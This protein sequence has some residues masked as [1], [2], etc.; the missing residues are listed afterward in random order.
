VRNTFRKERSLSALQPLIVLSW[1]A[2]EQFTQRHGAYRRLSA[3]QTAKNQ[4]REDDPTPRDE[5]YLEAL[6][7]PLGCEPSRCGTPS[8][9]A[10]D[11]SEAPCD[12]IAI[13]CLF[14]RLRSRDARCG[15]AGVGRAPAHLSATPAGN[16]I[17]AEA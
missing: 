17:R 7:V 16:R 13:V 12:T 10:C 5:V 14:G 3:Y 4:T 11:K 9:A 6:K 2:A 8:S 15:H 1:H